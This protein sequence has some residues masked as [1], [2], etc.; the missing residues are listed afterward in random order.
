VLSN[1]KDG[2]IVILEHL[3]GCTVFIWHS[4]RVT[5]TV[6]RNVSGRSSR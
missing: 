3:F 2:T 1:P 4:Q 5:V 6:I